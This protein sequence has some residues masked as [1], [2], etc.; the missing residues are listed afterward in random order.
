[1]PCVFRGSGRAIGTP[2]LGAS[3]ADWLDRWGAGGRS[4]LSPAALCRNLC[5]HE[6]AGLSG[7]FAVGGDVA[8]HK[9]DPERSG[10][11]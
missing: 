4:A 11:G 10:R 1:M 7:Q 5:F 9:P 6:L 8:R 2:S 3:V